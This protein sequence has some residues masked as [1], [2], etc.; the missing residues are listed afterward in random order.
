MN[1]NHYSFGLTALLMFI[2]QSLPAHDFKVDG[3]YYTYL[4][5]SDKTVA[6]S[7]KYPEYFEY[8]KRDYSG[9]VVIP[10]TVTY[11]GMTYSVTSIGDNAFRNCTELT[12]IEIPNSVTSIGCIAFSYCI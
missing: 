10:P 12:S 8:S 2:C 4:S 11:Q 1:H 6:V 9:N 3:I 7:S 5:Q